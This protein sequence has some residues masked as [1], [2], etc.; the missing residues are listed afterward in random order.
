MLEIGYDL[1]GDNPRNWDNLGWFIT[2]ESDYISPDEYPEL[3]D[4]IKKTG[5]EASD[6]KEHIE[7]IKEFFNE[8]DEEVLAIYPITRFEHGVVKYFLGT[9]NGFDY[10]NCGFYII[11]SD[12]IKAYGLSKKELKGNTE[13]IIE[14]ELKM[15]NHYVNGE[16]YFFK[17][18]D[19][20]GEVIESG[21]DIFGDLDDVFE[22]IKG[23]LGK[24]WENE[25]MNDYFN[26]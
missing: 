10:S 20:N 19:E 17:L 24:E 14:G 23:Y 12:T 18:Y 11:T 4:W 13:K 25:D 8:T 6:V 7:K 16:V 15:Y 5:D 22:E 26:N 2:C 1:M 21:G 9:S 3:R